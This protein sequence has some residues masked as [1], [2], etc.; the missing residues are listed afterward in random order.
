MATIG[1]VSWLHG[2]CIALWVNHLLAK[3][4][5]THTSLSLSKHIIIIGIDSLVFRPIQATSVRP[6]RSLPTLDWTQ[7]TM[8][9]FVGFH[10][11]FHGSS[12]SVTCIQFSLQLILF[13]YFAGFLSISVSCCSISVRFLFLDFFFFFFSWPT[14]KIVMPWPKLIGYK[15]VDNGL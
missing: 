12:P 2:P 4:T 14:N 13:Y 8:N 1:W 3:H 11:L 5:Y 7:E 6:P 10:W 15:R 9:S